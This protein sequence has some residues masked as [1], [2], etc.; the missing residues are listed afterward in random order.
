M[1]TGEEQRELV[2]LARVSSPL[3]DRAGPPSDGTTRWPDTGSALHEAVAQHA[4]R[5]PDALAV[6]SDDGHLTFRQLHERA[7]HLAGRFRAA[8]VGPE[9]RIAVLLDRSPSAVVSV[10]AAFHAGGV[11]VPLGTEQPPERLATV[12][13]DLAPAL[14]VTDAS[15]RERI[16]DTGIPVL[17]MEEEGPSV[18]PGELPATDPDGLAYMIYTSGS[19][20]RPKAVMV[21]HR[22][23]THH[24]ES[25]RSTYRSSPGDRGVLLSALTFDLAMEQI[26]LPLFGGG[27]IMVADAAFWAPEG[28]PDRLESVGAAHHLL[29]PSHYREV[30]QSAGDLSER[31]SRLRALHIGA[32]VVTYADAQSWFTSGAPGRFVC[33]Y[34]PTE[35]TIVALAHH[36]NSEEAQAADPSTSVPIG[37]PVPGCV[38]YVL[39]PALNLVPAGVPGE[40]HIGGPRVARGYLGRPGLTAERY[41]PDPFEGGGGRLYATGD[42]ALIRCDGTI[43]FLGRIDSQVKIRGFRVELGEVEAA[44]NSHG[45]VRESAVRAWPTGTVEHRLV[46]YVVAHDGRMPSVD[47]LREHLVERLP[48]HMVPS[49]FVRLDALPLTTS[50]KLDRTALP[51]PAPEDFGPQGAE[52]PRTEVEEA[53][54]ECWSK[55]LGV[56]CVGLE[57]DFFSLGGHSLTA[58]RLLTLLKDLFDLDVPLRLLFDENTVRGQAAALERIAEAQAE[59]PDDHLM[60][61]GHGD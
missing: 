48:D 35:A 25:I 31:L 38:A 44:L 37:R 28:L 5:T 1:L 47:G 22:S 24:M 43:E 59:P 33:V 9:G 36:V 29:T 6:L 46:G 40:L 19:T 14:V 8:G 16:G 56:P 55:V 57:E 42:R 30:M 11:Y 17:V 10:L 20:G 23:Y 32:D 45:E 7:L 18:P 12:F 27:A 50:R 53:V 15:Y 60:C 34:G 26:G 54:A 61:G 51:H 58:T 21:T 39:D 3:P 4:E 2:A 13:E 52:E 49:A 41:V